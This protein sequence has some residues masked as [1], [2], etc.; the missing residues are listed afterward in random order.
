MAKITL[1]DIEIEKLYNLIIQ[2]PG[3][4]RFIVYSKQCGGLGTVTKVKFPYRIKEIPADVTITITDE[5][6]W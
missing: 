5:T 1:S 3:E 6:T 4:N 2:F